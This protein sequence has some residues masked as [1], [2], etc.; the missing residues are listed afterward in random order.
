M[1]ICAC[2]LCIFKQNFKFCPKPT[3]ALYQKNPYD[4]QLDLYRQQSMYGSSKLAFMSQL[5]TVGLG[6]FIIKKKTSLKPKK[7]QQN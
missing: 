3:I 7:A 1:P 2:L 6:T 5:L 4:I